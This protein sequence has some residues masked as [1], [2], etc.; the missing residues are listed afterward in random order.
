MKP[1]FKEPK[2]LHI[3]PKHINIPTNV[4]DVSKFTFISPDNGRKYGYDSN[5]T[6]CIS[7][8]IQN[9]INVSYIPPKES[10]SITYVSPYSSFTH[11]DSSFI[12]KHNIFS[13]QTH[14]IIPLHN[15][16][17]SNKKEVT[18]SYEE[19][20]DQRIKEANEAYA[21]Q[22]AK[23][24][25]ERELVIIANKLQ[26]AKEFEATPLGIVTVKLQQAEEIYAAKVEQYKNIPHNFNYID[27]RVIA[28]RQVD[29]AAKQVEVLKVLKYK[30]EQEDAHDRW[31]TVEREKYLTK[32]SQEDQAF[33]TERYARIDNTKKKLYEVELN[34]R[35]YNTSE[36]E[37]HY[38]KIVTT[39]KQYK[40]DYH[41]FNKQIISESIPIQALYTLSLKKTKSVDSHVVDLVFDLLRDNH[42]PSLKTLDLSD[43]P[44]SIGADQIAKLAN[45]FFSGNN[46][47]ESLDISCIY[48][49][50]TDLRKEGYQ[51]RGEHLG[52]DQYKSG[53]D[54]LRYAFS[55][56][57]VSAST[58]NQPLCITIDAVI[59]NPQEGYM[60][61]YG[62]HIAPFSFIPQD[63]V[64]RGEPAFFKTTSVHMLNHIKQV[65]PMTRDIREKQLLILKKPFPHNV[66][67]LQNVVENFTWGITKCLTPSKVTRK[68]FAW[69]QEDYHHYYEFDYLLPKI[70][71]LTQNPLEVFV[72]I[73]EVMEDSVISHDMLN[74]K[75]KWEDVFLPKYIKNSI[76][77]RKMS[78]LDG[79]TKQPI[80][81]GKVNTQTFNSSCKHC[82]ESQ[83]AHF[84]NILS[85]LEKNDVTAMTNL[86]LSNRDMDDC[87][88]KILAKLIGQGNL[89]NLKVLDVSGNQITT[90]GEG[91]FAK[92]LE[93][94]KVTSISIILTTKNSFKELV[95]FIKTG[96]NYY[97]QEFHIEQIAMD[98]ESQKYL[99]NCQKTGVN[100]VFGGLAGLTKCYEIS[101]NPRFL[102]TCTAQEVFTSLLQPEALNCL[103][104]IHRFFEH[105]ITSLTGAS[106]DQD[107]HHQECNIF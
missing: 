61:E 99:T 46:K 76:G 16:N 34:P 5:G 48:P 89:P 87:D 8:P 100:A 44:K 11:Q 82:E 63:T 17:I 49:P 72:C 41:G 68:D 105:E 53:N 47:L 23:I 30:T 45:S 64:W 81:K 15:I 29:Q 101:K 66:E 95:N 102:L 18:Q 98:V 4:C 9:P 97:A 39:L 43:N 106:S 92:T 90:T 42:L 54:N 107:I 19:Q 80:T 14:N 25:Q 38:P 85:I 24:Q 74:H 88:A 71:Q 33:L 12:P 32:L 79:L 91:Y 104:D 37:T 28:A 35:E 26:Q 93:S 57:L 6:P 55:K 1:N 59:S 75:A 62:L 52:G 10:S 58:C 77:I 83:F 40:S 2:T 20:K 3:Q 22:Q 103:T 50:P 51:E 31:V 65:L 94:V 84:L 7:K 21:V 73:T 96:F 70:V 27:N 60:P 86:N 78:G 36:V 67:K 69:I 13:P 56:L